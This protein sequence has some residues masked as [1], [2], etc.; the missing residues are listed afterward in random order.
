MRLFVVVIVVLFALKSNSQTALPAFVGAQGFGA[1]ATGGRGGRVIAVTNLRAGGAGSLQDALDQTGARTIVFRVSGVIEGIPTLSNG[2]V[3]IAGQTSPSGVTVRGLL[4]QGDVVCED[5]GCPLPRRA[6]QNVIVR[7]LRSRAALDGDGLRLHR[8]KRVIADHL[9][10]GNANDEAVQVSFSSDIT[11]QNSLFAETIGDHND[12]GGV[13]LN[14][15]DPKRNFPLTRIA[16][17]GNVWTR[18]GGRIPELSRENPS[19]TGSNMDIEISNNVFHDHTYPMAISQTANTNSSGQNGYQSAPIYYRANMVGNLSLQNPKNSTTV[20]M[21]TFEGAGLPSEDY[22]P[23]NTPTRFYLHDN[24]LLSAKDWQTVYCCN[25]FLDA[26]RDNAMPF[27]N[28]Q[29]AWAALER[30]PFPNVAYIPSQQLLE[31]SKNVGMLPRDAFDQRVMKFVSSGGFDSAP[32][33]LNPAKDALVLPAAAAAPL[34]SD[35]DAMPD[36]WESQNGLNPKVPDNNGMGLSQK[37]LGVAGYTNLEV[38]L[39][40]LAQN[41]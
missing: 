24:R 9:S 35:S 32:R 27:Y 12:L 6:P 21:F 38:Y 30:L 40:W 10:I 1:S 11:I 20:G 4:I 23:A 36:G 41:R 3:T 19:A 5:D 31:N 33:S 15:S 7:F 18:I 2:D 14:Y 34:D 25:D 26:L 39:Q 17:L 8:A 37:I 13:L 16:L 22:L 29:P 28:R